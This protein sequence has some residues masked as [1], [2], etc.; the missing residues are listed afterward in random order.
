M[1]N[2]C[3]NVISLA[4]NFDPKSKSDPSMDLGA[5]SA[6]PQIYKNIG[7]S[8]LSQNLSLTLIKNITPISLVKL[9]I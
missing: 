4:F 5:H 9:L 3:S 6:S 8:F 7:P 2:L 1:Y